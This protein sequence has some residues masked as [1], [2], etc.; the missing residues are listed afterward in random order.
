MTISSKLR[1][2]CIL[3]IDIAHPPLSAELAETVLDESLRTVDRSSQS[4]I[5]KI[6]H[7]YGSSGKGGMLKTTVQ[8]WTYRH[9]TEFRAIIDGADA[10]PFDP[11]IQHMAAEC[12]LSIQSD[13]GTANNGITIVWVK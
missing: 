4:R 13:I 1:M 9:R 8:N 7:G 11:D 10:S 5:L 12:N 3:T 2:S 6:I